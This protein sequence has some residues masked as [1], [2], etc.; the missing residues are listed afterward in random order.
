MMKQKCAGILTP[1]GKEFYRDG[2]GNGWLAI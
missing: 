1:A 2:N